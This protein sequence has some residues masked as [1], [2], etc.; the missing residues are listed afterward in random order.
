[1]DWDRVTKND[2]IG[3]LQISSKNPG[4]EAHHWNE[5][6]NCPRK[7]IA[8]WLH[9]RLKAELPDGGGLTKDAVYLRG[10]VEVATATGRSSWDAPRTCR[11]CSSRLPRW[12]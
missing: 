9:D 12:P 5:V 2:V 6:M 8:E 4:N 11:S 1:M 7:Q 3:R 10:L